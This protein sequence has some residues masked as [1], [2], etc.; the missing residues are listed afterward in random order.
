MIKLEEKYLSEVRNILSRHLDK[1]AEVY[2]FGSRVNGN[3]KQYSDLDIS[4]NAGG[5]KMQSQLLTAIKA[6]FD[7]SLIP[8]KVDI[9]DIN[10]ISEEFKAII[11]KKFE[12]LYF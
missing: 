4:V 1:N 2:V 11:L 5:L 12:R 3:H 10:G 9:V 8:V 7:N 6:D